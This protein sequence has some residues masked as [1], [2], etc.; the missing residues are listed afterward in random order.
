ML[1]DNLFVDNHGYKYGTIGVVGVIYVTFINN[2]FINNSAYHGGSIASYANDFV[3]VTYLNV[4]NCSSYLAGG[5]IYIYRLF[6]NLTITNSIFYDCYSMI[7]GGCLFIDRI[8]YLIVENTSIINSEAENSGGSAF[9]LKGF[10]CIFNNFSIFKSKATYGG[11]IYIDQV[12]RGI[13]QNSFFKNGY[14]ILDGGFGYFYNMYTI[15]LIEDSEFC[16]LKSERDGAFLISY[17]LSYFL[18]NRTKIFYCEVLHGDKGVFFL[19]GFND[20]EFGE[21]SGDFFIENTEFIENAAQFGANIYFTSN[22]YL[23]LRNVT[24]KNNFGNLFTIGSDKQSK[25]FFNLIKISRNNLKFL[26]MN[27]VADQRYSSMF[28]I[29]DSDIIFIN[30]SINYN[31]DKKDL[32]EIYRSTIYVG[33]S[34]FYE[35]IK[36]KFSEEMSQTIFNLIKSKIEL[37]N[38]TFFYLYVTQQQFIIFNIIESSFSSN[39]DFYQNYSVLSVSL[40]FSQNSNL[41]FLNSYFENLNALTSALLIK[42]SNLNMDLCIFGV[43]ENLTNVKGNSYILYENH[44]K[45][46]F[47]LTISNSLFKNFEIDI[48]NVY[49][50]YFLIIEN[51]TFSRKTVNFTYFSRV[52]HLDS[53]YHSLI[54]NCVFQNLRSLLSACIYVVS[55]EERNHI[56]EVKILK[57]KFLS[58]IAMTAATI[59]IS[60]FL[61]IEINSSIFFDNMAIT[62]L[63]QND[64]IINE[65]S[66]KAGCI[67]IDCEYFPNCSAGFYSAYF[68]S[69]KAEKF[70]STILLKTIDAAHFTS[71]IFKNNSDESNYLDLVTGTPL[72]NRLLHLNFT[73]EIFFEFLK[74][75]TDLHSVTIQLL[76]NF[77]SDHPP[78]ATSGQPFNLSFLLLDF[79]FQILLPSVLSSDFTCS[80]SFLIKHNPIL[81]NGLIFFENIKVFH[82]PNSTIFCLLSFSVPNNLFFQPLNQKDQSSLPPPSFS[83]SFTIFLRLCKIGE[84]FLEDSS[85]F[86]CL[87]GTFSLYDHT[88]S[89]FSKT[90]RKCTSCPANAFCSGASSLTPSRGYWRANFN[91]LLFLKCQNEEGCL[92]YGGSLDYWKNL[93]SEEKISGKCGEGYSGN[94]CFYCDQGSA[95]IDEE[96]ICRK[97]E[98]L[99]GRKI[100]F[101]LLACFWIFYIAVQ[102]RVYGDTEERDPKLAILIKIM[103]NH[104][105]MMLIMDLIE[106]R[107]IDQFQLFLA[108]R[109]YFNFLTID[110]FVFD[111]LFWDIG[112]DMLVNKVIF[113]DVFP[114]VFSFIML[115]LWMVNYAYF[116]FRNLPTFEISFYDYIK[117]RIKSG[118]VIFISIFYP[119]ILRK[120]FSLFNCMLIDEKTNLTVLV[121]SPNIIC[122][123]SK[124][125]F[126]V[127]VVATPGLIFWGILTPLIILIVLIRNKKLVATYITKIESK[128]YSCKEVEIKKVYKRTIID[129]EPQLAEK[130]FPNGLP[131]K[132]EIGCT[133]QHTSFIKSREFFIKSQEMIMKDFKQFERDRSNKVDSVIKENKIITNIAEL[134]RYIEN[135]DQLFHKIGENDLRDYKVSVRKE[136]EI[137]TSQA[138]RKISTINFLKDRRILIYNLGFI[139]RG[140]KKDYFCWEIIIFARKFLFIFIGTF[141]EIFP[142]HIKPTMFVIMSLSFIYFQITANPYQFDYMNNLELISLNMAFFTAC[143]GVLLFSEKIKEI[144]IVFVVIVFI[145]NGIFYAKWIEY[146]FKHGRLRKDLLHLM[147]I[148]KTK[149]SSRKKVIKSKFGRLHKKHEI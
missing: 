41:T 29:L 80:S 25:I 84:V 44:E 52:L 60:G 77:L 13:W 73:P 31:C 53:V 139:Y 81:L 141:T 137:P 108:A 144:S 119:E 135:D 76:S 15:I 88:L 109:N 47:N 121:L 20:F 65:N 39:N 55:T 83:H 111:C 69:N 74:S 128:F 72:S 116:H 48:I 43:I 14:S 71:C 91:S 102:V 112:E 6:Q 117:E 95:K 146:I 64:Y 134:Y 87:P 42:N 46:N 63:F 24:S 96:G 3:D 148:L 28:I 59:Y 90:S 122:W 138:R 68:L 99:T 51:C 22:N 131:H 4:F 124:H 11:M 70:G 34:S 97:C 114:F 32:F 98:D 100:K 145:I 21:E 17:T 106:F 2:T 58:N 107:N 37:F 19:E 67:L 120:C 126:W 62:N 82:I 142:N 136:S 130:L 12:N 101:A 18:V 147:G 33:Q 9:I 35:N 8:S 5:S 92:G 23:D 132:T 26:H 85:C 78:V 123:E 105:Q 61:S 127:Q 57:S 50:A 129:I 125:K 140:Y 38:N 45:K 49:K 56:F 7:D 110:F 113:A 143:I 89:N 93:T 118:L 16:D 10:F 104:L 36:S 40:I 149:A 54:S 30:I 75:S 103:V 94:L 66:G 86:E 1:L 79:N 27:D 115:I 133:K